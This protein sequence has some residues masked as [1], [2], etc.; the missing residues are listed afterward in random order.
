MEKFLQDITG[1]KLAK[2][3]FEYTEKHIE[4]TEKHR[5]EIIKS[6]SERTC[7]GFKRGIGNCQIW[8]R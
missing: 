3:E 6:V 8:N 5:I 4:N 7:I 2:G 1:H